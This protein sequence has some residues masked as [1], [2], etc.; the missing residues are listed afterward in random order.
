MRIVVAATAFV[1][2]IGAL[3][4]CDRVG[5]SIVGAP[6]AVAPHDEGV[7]DLDASEPEDV[8]TTPIDRPLPTDRGDVQANCD[9][10]QRSVNGVCVM[11]GELTFTL[12]W[13][14]PGNMDLHVVT[15]GTLEIYAGDPMEDDGTLEADD[16]TGTG[17]ENIYWSIEP[18]PGDYVV[19][20]VPNEIA[21]PTTFTM[22]ARY[23]GAIIAETT[24]TSPESLGDALCS[25]TAVSFV[26]T[27]TVPP[28]MP[29]M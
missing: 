28:T 9:G 29:D 27:V 8:P 5:R 13:D 23:H 12:T 16:A 6:E 2:S 7:E 1:F 19:C 10:G 20:A 22:T 26:A 14:R 17:P 18:P 25:E 15:P 3:T 4:A 21:G 11:D 24:G